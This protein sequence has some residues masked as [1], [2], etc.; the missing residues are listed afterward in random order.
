MEYPSVP[1]KPSPEDI[2]PTYVR[3]PGLEFAMGV[4]LFAMVLMVFFLIQSGVFITG[5]LDRTPD[6]CAAARR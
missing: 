4:A 2:Q 1:E 6:S 3:P 5:V